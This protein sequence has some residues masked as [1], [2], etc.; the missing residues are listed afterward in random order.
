MLKKLNNYKAKI[1]DV[2]N[3]W[4]FVFIELEN[5]K[6]ILGKVYLKPD[7]KDT[8]CTN[9]LSEIIQTVNDTYINV[10]IIVLGDFNARIGNLNQFEDTLFE[11]TKLYGHRSS[12]DRIVNARGTLLNEIMEEHG[13]ITLN[14]RSTSDNPA[15][16]TF[17]SSLGKSTICLDKF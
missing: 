5:V 6:L 1:I 7:L 14:G 17:L 8:H 13:F 12:L 11:S 16:Y 2:S 15:Q 10:P 4:I 3:L 9:S